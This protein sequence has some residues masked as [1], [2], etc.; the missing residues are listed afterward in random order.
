MFIEFKNL[1]VAYGKEFPLATIYFNKCDS[2]RF[3]REQG[4]ALS[5]SLAALFRLLQSLITYHKK[6]AVRLSL[7]IIAFLIKKRRKMP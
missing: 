3:L 4:I 5:G 1:N 2:E 7:L 6:R